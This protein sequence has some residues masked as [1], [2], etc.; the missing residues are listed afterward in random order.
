[1]RDLVPDWE[2]P[3]PPVL[4]APSLNYRIRSFHGSIFH[5]NVASTLTP[6]FPG[7]V[8]CLRM[9]A[10][11]PHCHSGTFSWGTT[12]RSWGWSVLPK[13]RT[14]ASHPL[15]ALWPREKKGWIHLSN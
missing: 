13:S 15:G 4:G 7:Q 14:N 12:L 6:R 8:S 9:G 2:A 5:L 3:W 10:V 11:P 1:M